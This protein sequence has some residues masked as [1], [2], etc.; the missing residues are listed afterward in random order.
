MANESKK[1]AALSALLE[2]DTLKAAAEKS[3]VSRRTLY[4]YLNNDR[5]FA[6]QFKVM[7]DNVI[8]SSMDDL[9]ERRKQAL[10]TVS[11]IMKDSKQGATVR[12]RA[13]Q[14]ILDQAASLRLSMEA[15]EVHTE[16]RT[17]PLSF[18]D[19]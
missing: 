1:A 2:C 19:E 4:S 10:E 5:Q 14:L 6:R 12:L 15:V 8:L 3:G 18:L 17:D 16:K 11:Q 7:Q 13:A 9:I